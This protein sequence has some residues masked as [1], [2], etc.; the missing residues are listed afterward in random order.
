MHLSTT[1]PPTVT[2]LCCIKLWSVKVYLIIK[3]C[4][5]NIIK[6]PISV[7]PLRI[8]FCPT[9]TSARTLCCLSGRSCTGLCWASVMP[10]SSSLDPTSWWEKTPRL[11]EMDRCVFHIRTGPVR[12]LSKTR[13]MLFQSI[14]KCKKTVRVCVCVQVCVFWW[15]TV[16]DWTGC[17]LVV[18]S[19]LPFILPCSYLPVIL[20]FCLSDCLYIL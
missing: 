9:G 16:I 1:P 4:K 19:V 2:I 18:K 5:L 7:Y 13:K 12:G 20:S 8:F 11:W 6:L 17:L 3:W 10:L 15:D 14:N